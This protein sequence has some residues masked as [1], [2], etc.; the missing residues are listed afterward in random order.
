MRYPIL[1][2]TDASIFFINKRA[3]TPVE[4]DR[5]VKTRGEGPEI[6]QKFVNE[7]VAELAS[8]KSRFPEGLKSAKSANAFEALAARTIHSRVAV[9]VDI[10]ADPDF[11]LWLAAVHFS[12]IVE[13]R[14]GNPKGGTGAANYGVGA[15]SENLLYR[16][17]LRAELV[18]DEEA[19]DRYHLCDHGQIDFYRSH[20][21]RQGYA[22]ARN[23]ARALIRFQYPD[24]ADATQPFLKVDQI[25][26]LVKRLRRLRTNLFMEILDEVE[27]RKVIDEE[28]DRV[29]EAA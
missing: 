10:L 1:T 4:L 24:K 2:T 6:C 22:N 14:Y 13:W 29:P 9:G 7:L 28:I 17:W 11:W 20:L 18:L 26:E 5:L 21:F 25:R 8:I 15:R 3:G 16:L 12:D 23:F 27:C 19:T